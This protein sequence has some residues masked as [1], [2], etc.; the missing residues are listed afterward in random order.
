MGDSF[1]KAFFFGTFLLIGL[2]G[3]IS[4]LHMEKKSSDYRDQ[5]LYIES[6]GAADM[7]SSWKKQIGRGI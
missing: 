7:P 5:R 4:Y 1:F 3:A 2:V 6:R